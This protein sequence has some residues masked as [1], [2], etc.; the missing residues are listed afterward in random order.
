MPIPEPC[1]FAESLPVGTLLALRSQLL[2]MAQAIGDG[3]IIVTE[4]TVMAANI[5]LADSAGEQF[6]ALASAPFSAL[7]TAVPNATAA[8][9]VTEP[10]S[11]QVL[12]TTYRVGLTFDPQAIAATLN[13]W[14]DRCP[15][16]AALARSLKKMRSLPQPNDPTLQ[17]QFTLRL[18][19]TLAAPPA[20]DPN[21]SPLLESSLELTLQQQL[22]QERLLMQVIIQI[23]QSLELPVILETAVEQMRQFLNVDRL[24]V[25]QLPQQSPL[26][27]AEALPSPPSD[28][29]IGQNGGVVIHESRATSQIP[30]VLHWGEDLC[31]E[32][33]EMQRA[34][35][36]Q[37]EIL[38]IADVSQQYSLS[39]CL[40]DFLQRASIK[41][42]LV[43]PILVYGQVWGFLI[44]HDCHQSR[45]WQRHEKKFLTQIADHLAIAISQSQ[46]YAQLRQQTQTLER[47]VIER[48]QELHDAMLV[49]QSANRTKSRFIA[50]VSHE[51]RTPLTCIIGMSSTLLRWSEQLGE[52]QRS[53]LQAI[54]DSGGNL[55]EIINNILELSQFESGQEILNVSEFSLSFL[56][57]QSLSLFREK[58]AASK[59]SLE[60]DLQLDPSRDRFAADPL[61]V[62][63]ILLNLLSNAIKFTPPQGNV[64]LR[65]FL[66]DNL[67]VFQ[68]QDTGIGIPEHKRSL[69]F[70]TFQQLDDSYQ[71][72]YS[73]TGLGLALTKQLIDLHG[74]WIQVDSVVDV[75][76][77]F[78]VRLPRQPLPPVLP[79]ATRPDAALNHTMTRRIVVLSGQDDSADIIC[80]VLNAA[81]YQIIW[82]TEGYNAANQIE[83][84]HPLMVIIDTQ[85]ADIDSYELIR[86]LR[87]K[88]LTQNLGIIA[89]ASGH[90]PEEG[91]RGLAAGANDYVT[92]PVSP[93]LI[94]RKVSS[95][96]ANANAPSAAS[97]SS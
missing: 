58:A 38:A 76:S 52:Q 95:L 70:Q 41:A 53:F 80:D 16:K 10:T 22:E 57:Q 49:S 40:L 63:Q 20:P 51:L 36:L 87:Q 93:E 81:D 85:L 71:R 74:G 5:A 77:T 3:G 7:L 17:G 26:T 50:S 67:A 4:Q 79:S 15:P 9:S 13:A 21:P 66:E 28:Y 54:H 46:L 18:M 19:Q 37:G 64:T 62:R 73:G 34:K 56:V 11:D 92:K 23:R 89:I 39:P 35:Y 6:V 88:P 96:T 44:A 78:T 29:G 48:T 2:N 61:R 14:L 24:V 97:L 94:L 75:G 47:R 1:P 32:H 84:L 59:I 33:V 42:K 25:Y 91:D 65:V 90:H 68:I 60:L 45:H 30:S 83:I 8:P 12:P 69:L 82:L 55:L 43:A 31:F 86:Q 27:E 72:E